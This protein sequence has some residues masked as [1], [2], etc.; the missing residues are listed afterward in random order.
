VLATSPLELIGVVQEAYAADL[1]LAE[2]GTSTFFLCLHHLSVARMYFLTGRWDDALD[3]YLAGRDAPSLYRPA[4]RRNGDE[5]G[6]GVQRTTPK[7][8]S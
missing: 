8:H 7:S 1:R 4:K 3:R 5:C 2:R 6:S